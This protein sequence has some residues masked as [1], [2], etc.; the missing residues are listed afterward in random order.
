MSVGVFF[1]KILEV[2]FV[3]GWL[4]S[5]LVLLITGAED[6]VTLLEEDEESH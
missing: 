4:G 6:V 5:V 1:V 2:M 3:A